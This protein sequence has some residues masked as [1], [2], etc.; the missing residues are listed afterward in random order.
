M[1][2]IITVCL[3]VIVITVVITLGVLAYQFMEVREAGWDYNRVVT[4]MNQWAQTVEKLRMKIDE[5]EK[6]YAGT[7]PSDD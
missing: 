7:P 6:I 5:I 2:A 4:A 1:I 3:T